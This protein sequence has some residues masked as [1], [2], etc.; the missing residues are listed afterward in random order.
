MS[1]HCVALDVYHRAGSKK[2]TQ[3]LREAMPDA[4]VGEPDPEGIIEVRVDAPDFEEA[5]HLVWNGIA[6]AGCDDHICFAEHPDIPQHWKRPGSDGQLPGA[7][8]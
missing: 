1:Q 7:L 8:V 2:C 4:E 6:A 5:L 3:Q